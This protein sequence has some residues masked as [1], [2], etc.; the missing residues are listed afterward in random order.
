[1]PRRE[2]GD[3]RRQ[4]SR[5]PRPA[6]LIVCGA[7]RTERDYFAGLR[8]QLGSRSIN[9]V[10]EERSGAPDQ[11]VNFTAAYEGA[12]DFEERWCVV[13]V[14]H[15][16]REGGKVS[17]AMAAGRSGGIGVAVSNPCFEYWL[18]LHH[19][20]RSFP[21]HACSEIAQALR[22]ALPGYDKVNLKFEQFTAG[23]ED[24]IQRARKRDPSGVEHT[25]NPSSGVWVLVEKLLEQQ[26]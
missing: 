8:S 19:A 11:V 7:H 1:M 18:L 22:K 2:R 9:I 20:D 16:E 12:Q 15:F 21:A 10:V 5:R 23:V 3:S 17:K 4:P 6:V 25:A 24:A 14:D 26:R 13:D